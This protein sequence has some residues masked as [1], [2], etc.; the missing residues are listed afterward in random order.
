MIP[1]SFDIHVLAHFSHRALAYLIALT[2]AVLY[3]S[4]ILDE[5]IKG[6]RRAVFFLL[7]LMVGQVSVGALVVLTGLYYMATALHLAVAL[8]MLYVIGNMWTSEV[9]TEGTAV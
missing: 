7:L 6:S 1:P 9:K 3:A 2:V 8:A 5:R 4:T